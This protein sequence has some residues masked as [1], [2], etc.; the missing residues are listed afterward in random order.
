MNIKLSR[1]QA[2][3]GG[4]GLAAIA[5]S[6]P[7]SAAGGGGGAPFRYSLNT[8]TIRGQELTLVQE[9]EIAAKAGY[10]AIEPWIGELD[11][12]VKEGGSLKDLRKRVEDRGLTVESSIGF[13][14]WIVDDDARRAKGLEEARRS[15]EMV[16]QLG[17]KRIAAPPVGA[18]D[19]S[20]MDLLKIAERYGA[21]LEVGA[22]IGVVPQVEVWGFSKTLNRVGAAA[23]VAMESGHA[24]ACVLADVYHVHRG[25]SGFAG[26]RLLD[27]A[28]MHVFH[29]NDYPAEPPREQLT[30]AHR[31]Y[32][33]DGV[34]P[35]DRLFR[36]LYDGGFRGV[37][38]LELFNRDYWK[39]DPLLVARNG[40]E[41]T[42]AAVKKS[43][44][45]R[46]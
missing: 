24:Q 29:V 44:A 13:A 16:A 9:V 42:R 21:L 40:L 37:L 8:S 10:D 12:H 46:R 7:A 39:Q 11:R 32:P 1:R 36:D 43:L 5:A 38:S 19:R 17:G 41:K 15:M 20:D 4:G 33:G 31:I 2:L 3:L 18:T 34:A 27:G 28:A 22:G 26:I 23:M 30:D 35:L 25:G 14:E 6:E 45:G